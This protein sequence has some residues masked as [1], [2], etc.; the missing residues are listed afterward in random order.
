MDGSTERV[1]RQWQWG[2]T[3]AGAVL[4]LAGVASTV[5]LLSNLASDLAVWVLGRSATGQVVE[6]WVERIGDADEGELSFHYY[7]RYEFTTASG[8]TI[9]KTTRLAVTEWSN[10]EVGGP[11]AVLYFPLYPSHARLAD[12]RFIGVYLCSYLPFAIAG[13]AGMSAGWYL[14]RQGAGRPRG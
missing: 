11:V 3:I 5:F 6:Q 2:R 13:W 7:V 8:R 4:L 1:T 10:L 9:T 12:Q 14:L